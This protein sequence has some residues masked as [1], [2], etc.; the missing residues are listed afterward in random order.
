MIIRD[1]RKGRRFTRK[2]LIVLPFVLG[3]MAFGWWITRPLAG[4]EP[5]EK[6]IV[7]LDMEEVSEENGEVYFFSNF[8]DDEKSLWI[9]GNNGEMER[10]ETDEFQTQVEVERLPFNFKKFNTQLKFKDVLLCKNKKS[11]NQMRLW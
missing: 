7:L 9:Y 3:L 6:D 11:Q 5:L 8:S 1:D 2:L 10:W 4:P